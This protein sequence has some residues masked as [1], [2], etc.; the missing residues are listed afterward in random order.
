MQCLV[1]TRCLFCCIIH[2]C[3]CVTKS[4]YLNFWEERL[5]QHPTIKAC[6]KISNHY[7]NMMS[8]C[9]FTFC[10]RQSPCLKV[11]LPD[12]GISHHDI[13]DCGS[14]YFVFCL[15]CQSS[16]RPG[17]LQRRPQLLQP[18]PQAGQ[19]VQSSIKCLQF[20]T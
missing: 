4:Y 8:V 2:Q 12:G 5:Y 13:I 15:C 10:L 7:K 11:K 3:N 17:Q 9:V 16:L 20:G 6:F 1:K 19:L 18:T 14:L